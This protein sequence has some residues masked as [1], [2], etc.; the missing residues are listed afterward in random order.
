MWT[1]PPNVY[2]TPPIPAVLLLK[3]Q[4]VILTDPSDVAMIPPTVPAPLLTKELPAIQTELLMVYMTPPSSAALWLKV[5]LA[6]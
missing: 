3:L 1:E 6:I 4:S 5:L 2:M